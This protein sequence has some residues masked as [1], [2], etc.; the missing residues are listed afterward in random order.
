[1]SGVTVPSTI[2]WISVASHPAMCQCFS[3]SFDRQIARRYALLDDMPLANSHPGHDPF[4]V[5]VDH[6]LEIGI[7]EKSR[8]HIGAQ[9][10]D[11]GADRFTQ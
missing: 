3:R 7:G 4:I 5:S 11:F 8:R 6:P 9:G 2:A 1:M 10:A